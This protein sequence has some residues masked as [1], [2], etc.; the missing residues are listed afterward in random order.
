MAPLYDKAR[1]G[2][3]SYREF[4]AAKQNASKSAQKVLISLCP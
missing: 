2:V 4:L 3:D 1:K